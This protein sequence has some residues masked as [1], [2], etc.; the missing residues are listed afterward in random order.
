MTEGQPLS[1]A[2]HERLSPLDK[3]ETRMLLMHVTGLSRIQ[4]ITRS[5]YPLSTS[6]TQ[7]FVELQQR[8]LAGEPIAYLTGERE[9]FGLPFY[10]SPAVLIP[11]ADTEL[12]VELGLQFAPQNSTLLD[13]GTGSGAIAIALAHERQDLDV[14]AVDISTEA[15]AIAKKNAA[16]I[17]PPDHL[18]L[19]HS[20]WYSALAGRVFQTIVSNPPYIVKDDPHLSQGDLRFEP[21]N[22][23]TDHAD[24]LSAYRHIIQGAHTH[25]AQQGWLLMEHGYHQAEEVRALLIAAGYTQVQSWR[26]LAGIERV[27]GG[28]RR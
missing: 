1:I 10:T 11:R 16:R 2:D 13:L 9:F 15:L 14:C 21:I 4:L 23:L 12:L 6:Q 17:L 27:S 3:L 28:Q 26:D 25:L 7:Q 18:Q 22:A 5:D 24:G 19:L 8:R 20:D